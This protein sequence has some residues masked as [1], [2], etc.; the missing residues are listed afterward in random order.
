MYGNG[1]GR[2]GGSLGKESPSSSSEG[3][4]QI[5][6]VG[7]FVSF[8]KLSFRPPV[9]V[10]CR[11]QCLA[12]CRIKSMEISSFVLLQLALPSVFVMQMANKIRYS[13]LPKCRILNGYGFMK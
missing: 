5:V 6:D 4:I 7:N 8:G 9:S 1:L 11:F 12:F 2:R 3:K 10:Q 13:L